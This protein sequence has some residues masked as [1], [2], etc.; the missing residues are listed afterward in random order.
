MSE[1]DHNKAKPPLQESSEST[2]SGCREVEPQTD[3]PET[4]GAEHDD[5]N[6]P[7]ASSKTT[8]PKQ[9][10]ANPPAEESSKQSLGGPIVSKEDALLFKQGMDFIKRPVY[11]LSDG[12]VDERRIRRNPERRMSS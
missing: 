7:E 5:A 4:P 9:D 1:P 2:G 11:Y 12:R 8:G 10:E 6:P 3:P